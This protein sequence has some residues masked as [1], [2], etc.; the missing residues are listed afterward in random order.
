MI[1]ADL[2]DAAMHR[3]AEVYAAEVIA[4]T[5]IPSRYHS[6][7]ATVRSHLHLRRHSKRLAPTVPCRSV[8]LGKSRLHPPKQR[9]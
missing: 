3:K 4:R 6:L 7:V 9:T 8:P 2:L 5:R 1:T